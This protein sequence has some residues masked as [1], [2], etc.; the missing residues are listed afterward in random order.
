MDINVYQSDDKMLIQ[1]TGR[2][3]LDEC[4]RLKSTVVP[5]IQPGVGTVSLDLSGV[6]FIDSA[7]LGVLVGMKVT[8]NKVRAKLQLVAPS[9]GVQ[10]ILMVSKLDS[11]FDIITGDEAKQLIDA[12]ATPENERK[13]VESGGGAGDTGSASSQTFQSPPAAGSSSAAILKE[14]AGGSVSPKEQIDRL[15]KS[16]VDFMKQRQFDKAVECYEQVLEIDS[17]YL[18]AI[19]NL[20]IVYEKKPEWQEL[21]IQQWEKVLKISQERGDQKHMERAQKHLQALQNA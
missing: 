10:D 15:C 12:I 9:K 8:S 21:A 3:V 1:L 4:D 6:D 5:L 13:S 2:V 18:P 14:A 7:G 11:I 17:N 19:N 20:G 16:A